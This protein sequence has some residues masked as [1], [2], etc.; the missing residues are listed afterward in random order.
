[1]IDIAVLKRLAE[2]GEDPVPVSRRFLAQIADEL[3]AARSAE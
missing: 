1:M 2:Q 3:T